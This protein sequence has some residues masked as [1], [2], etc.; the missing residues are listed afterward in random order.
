MV[1]STC[2]VSMTAR[3][4]ARKRWSEHKSELRAS[5]RSTKHQHPRTREAP[6]T[7]LQN[8]TEVLELGAWNFIGIW[9]LDFGAS[10]RRFEPPACYVSVQYESATMGK[11]GDG[12]HGWFGAA[13]SE[14]EN[15]RRYSRETNH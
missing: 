6:S 10:I 3:T 4:L 7:K 2:T 13:H 1:C 8:V 14:P 11:S 5:L 12:A 9:S 15:G